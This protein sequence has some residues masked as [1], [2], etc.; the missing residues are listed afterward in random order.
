MRVEKQR[1]ERDCCKRDGGSSGDRSGIQGLCPTFHPR[2]G[3]IR[4]HGWGHCPRRSDGLDSGAAALK[5]IA[6]AGGAEADGRQANTSAQCWATC[7]PAK[8]HT[9]PFF[10]TPGLV[11]APRTPHHIG[12][13]GSAVQY[14]HVAVAI[15]I[16]P[17]SSG[18]CTPG[19]AQG[20]VRSPR[21]RDGHATLP[22]EAVRPGRTRAPRAV[23]CSHPRVAA[24]ADFIGNHYWK[25]QERR[26]QAGRG[27]GQRMS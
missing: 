10:A 14:T 20:A 15:N 2:P 13:P 4:S 12:E 24:A 11:V 23:V 19:G 8:H 7:R 9:S 25:W 27:T 16:Q 26:A 3:L 18:E 22:G 5:Q 21:G 17:C 1:G 6:A